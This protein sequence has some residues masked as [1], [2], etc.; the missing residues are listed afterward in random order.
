MSSRHDTKNLTTLRS[1][2]KFLISHQHFETAKLLREEFKDVLKQKH[3]DSVVSLEDVIRNFDRCNGMVFRHLIE[4]GHGKTAKKLTK[5]CSVKLEKIGDLKLE[6][7]VHA[8][9]NLE[10]IP[11]A[12]AFPSSRYDISEFKGIGEVHKVL[13]YILNS[14]LP[15]LKVRAERIDKD[16]YMYHTSKISK[17]Y[18]ELKRLKLTAFP[19]APHPSIPQLLEEMSMLKTLGQLILK[20]K[21]IDELVLV[22]DLLSIMKQKQW[23]CTLVGLYLSK[24]FPAPLCDVKVFEWLSK[25]SLW[26]CQMSK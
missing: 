15:V 19:N 13:S 23:P 18:Q 20:A 6:N 25:M 1:V 17:D 3:E 8:Q 22:E 26:W 21:V 4:A 7:L 2:Y 11:I 16:S 12:E 5:L 10:K 14:N 24:V 9:E